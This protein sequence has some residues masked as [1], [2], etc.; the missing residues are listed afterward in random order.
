METFVPGEKAM[1]KGKGRDTMA[2]IAAAMLL[3]GLIVLVALM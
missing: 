2:Y 3:V 1:L